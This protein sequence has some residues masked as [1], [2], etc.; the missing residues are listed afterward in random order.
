MT[1]T[2]L[3]S[4][5]KQGR[6]RYHRL[7][8]PSVASMVESIM[9]VASELEPAGRKLSIGPKDA[10]LRQ[11]RTCYDH[12]AGQLGV[13]IADGLMRDGYVE[14]A[15]DAGIVTNAGI[16]RLTAIGMDV[17]KILERTKHSGR[18]LC[19]P[20]LDWSERRPH[21]AGMLGALICEHSIQQGWIRRLPGT[22]AVQLTP[23]GER[24]F[25]EGFGAQLA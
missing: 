4:V 2:G 25:R 10:A 7:A 23:E 9:Q 13:S 24:A 14:L 21:L 11:A 3:L 18:V 6:H 22:R 17:R 1:A 16:A 15:G 20:C 5:E 12:L 19:R 8:T